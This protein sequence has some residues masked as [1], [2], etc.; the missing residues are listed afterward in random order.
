MFGARQRYNDATGEDYRRF[1][2][3]YSR[4]NSYHGTNNTQY[5]R[6]SAHEGFGRRH[7]AA[8]GGVNAWHAQTAQV[9]LNVVKCR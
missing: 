3:H 9:S 8:G 6:A 2:S 4:T 5:R 7:S 1:T